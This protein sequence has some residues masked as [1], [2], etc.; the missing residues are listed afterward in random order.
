MQHNIKFIQ[1]IKKLPQKDAINIIIITLFWL[2]IT[3]LVNPIGDFPLNDDWAYAQSVKYFLDTGKFQLPGWAVANLLPQVFFGVLFCLPGGFSFTALRFSTLTLGLLGVIATYFL[4]KEML[5]NR[6]IAFLGSLL[7][8]FNPIYFQLS[9]TFMTDVPHY[10]VSV[11]SLYLFCLG[12]K[13]DSVKIIIS[14]LI[15]ALIALLIRQVTGALFC[16]YLVT[17]IFK[18]KARIKSLINASLLFV[19]IPVA[20]QFIFAD[21]FW[22]KSFGNYGA[23]EEQFISQLSSIN[24]QTGLI[25]IE[26]V[27]D[28]FYLALCVLLYSGCFLLPWLLLVFYSKLESIESRFK[29]NLLIGCLLFLITIIASWFLLDNK[30]IPLQGN[31][32]IDWGLGPLTLRD[33]LLSSQPELIPYNLNLFWILVTILSIIGAALLILFIILAAVKF[34]FD[35]EIF[36]TKR[37]QVMVNTATAFVYFLPLGLNF[38]FDRYLLWFLP[39]L[40]SIALFFLGE[41]NKLKISQK[42]FYLSLIVTIVIGGLTVAATHDYLS[43]N[44]I[45]WQAINQLMVEK[46]IS[47]E[48]IDGG[49]EFNGWY[50]YN[51][52]Y[53]FYKKRK[54][55]EV[56]WWVKQD[57]YVIS[58]SQIDGYK[59]IKQYYLKNW[60]PFKTDSILVL[61]KD[62]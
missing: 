12:I 14:S 55:Q 1:Y 33:N 16:G 36:W 21:I 9:N 19:I 23:K 6:Q 5:P 50:L 51:P 56:W 4:L 22:P 41:T 10:T 34:F 8:A 32:I 24:S 13:K 62:I 40:M 17:Y 59:T 28:F 37:S 20:V 44:R 30:K 29:K 18:Y 45:R 39:L 46:A 31:I 3:I 2:A 38:F 54:R 11:L 25:N 61:E 57:D 47:P 49:F 43:W 35:R 60:L 53:N 15:F 52:Q 42:Q 7:V 58:F 27:V 48:Y 26:G